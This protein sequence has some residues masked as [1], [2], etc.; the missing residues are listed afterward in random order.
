MWCGHV[1]FCCPFSLQSPSL[2]VR[3][4]AAAV[5]PCVCDDCWSAGV[6]VINVCPSTAKNSDNVL[7]LTGCVV[8][9]G[10]ASKVSVSQSPQQYDEVFS[11]NVR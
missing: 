2:F 7:W 10:F 11:A 6:M 4:V 1:S 5:A 3:F 8:M 9:Y